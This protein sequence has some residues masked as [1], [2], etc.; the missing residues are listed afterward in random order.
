MYKAL[1]VVNWQ[2][3]NII[4]AGSFRQAHIEAKMDL[5]VRRF[6][7]DKNVDGREFFNFSI[8]DSSF[9]WD[10]TSFIMVYYSII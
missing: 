1:R 4:P 9:I 8:F 5:F 7:Y 2:K 10:V 6:S 3:R